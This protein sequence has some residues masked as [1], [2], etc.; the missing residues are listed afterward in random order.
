MDKCEIHFRFQS[1]QHFIQT[2][3]HDAVLAAKRWQ[4][5]R[6]L[7]IQPGLVLVRALFPNEA[8][9]VRIGFDLGTIYE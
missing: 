5:R 7:F 9:F 1:R 2:V 8:V 4:Q 6:S 3:R